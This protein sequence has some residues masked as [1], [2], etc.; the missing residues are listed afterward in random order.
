MSK[1]KSSKL[2]AHA[3]RLTEW[4]TPA[5]QGGKG[6]TLDQAREQLALD[7]VSVSCSR[8]SDWWSDRQG[9]MLQAQVLANIRSGARDHREVMAAFEKNPAPGMEA[10]INLHRL[11]A[12]QLASKGASDPAMLELSTKFT[13]T[14]LDFGKLQEQRAA[15]ELAERKY[16]D[17]AEKAKGL[18]EDKELSEGERAS[19]MRELFGI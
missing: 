7:G 11:V 15:R 12:Y 8:L 13:K 5:D 2:D 6:L 3:E 17:Q 10:I 19:K 16:R 1:Q 18:L 14:I 9:E 4:F